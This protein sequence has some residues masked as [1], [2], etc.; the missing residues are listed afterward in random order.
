MI[1]ISIL[2]MSIWSGLAGVFKDDNETSYIENKPK[3]ISSKSLPSATITNFLPIYDYTI[4]QNNDFG[5]TLKYPKN[6]EQ[7]ETHTEMN[8][9]LGTS[10]EM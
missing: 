8:L 7:K 6:W 3:T 9:N 2:M 5:F 1:I 4:Y 10:M